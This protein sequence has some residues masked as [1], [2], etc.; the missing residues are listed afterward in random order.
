[1]SKEDTALFPS[2]HGAM[3]FELQLT[4]LSITGEEGFPSP[5]GAMEFEL[6]RLISQILLSVFC[7]RPLTGQWNLNKE[8][9]RIENLRLRFRPLTG[10]WNLNHLSQSQL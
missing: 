10:Q 9:E 5:H 8:A 3:E 7:F 1:M 6:P 4:C 2:P